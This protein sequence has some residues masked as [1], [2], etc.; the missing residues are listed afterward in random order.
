MINVMFV[1]LSLSLKLSLLTGNSE[2]VSQFFTNVKTTWN[3][4]STSKGETQQI[5]L[6]L[7][8]QSS[9]LY[10][11]TFIELRNCL[12]KYNKVQTML[13]QHHYI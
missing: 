12:Q 13:K 3:S 10:S 4:A 8:N 6:I 7:C 5:I 11:Q 2:I 1:Y 9:V